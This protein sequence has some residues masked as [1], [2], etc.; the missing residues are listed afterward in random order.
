L[1]WL[2]RFVDAELDLVWLP[3]HRAGDLARQRHRPRDRSPILY[4]RPEARFFRESDPGAA[5]EAPL[6]PAVE[7]DPGRGFPHRIESLAQLPFD[8]IIRAWVDLVRW[9]DRE[10]DEAGG[11]GPPDVLCR[12]QV[13]GIRAHRSAVAGLSR[14]GAG[15]V[16]H[17][18]GRST[19]ARHLADRLLRK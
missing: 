11:G 13:I 14:S 1:G 12:L 5:G 19:G 16:D 8:V 15:V 18:S 17:L 2:L 6:A 7:F 9:I 3:R 10:K 4:R